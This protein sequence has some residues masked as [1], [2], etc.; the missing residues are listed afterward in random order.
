MARR[1]AAEYNGI[2]GHSL[3]FS[4]SYEE[5]NKFTY[6]ETE[7]TFGEDYSNSIGDDKGVRNPWSDEDH[8]YSLPTDSQHCLEDFDHVLYCFFVLG[9]FSSQNFSFSGE[10]F[11]PVDIL[12]EIIFSIG[13]VRSSIYLLIIS[14]IFIF[15]FNLYC[16]MMIWKFILMIGRT[17]YS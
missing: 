17:M 16:S 3:S 6:G 14:G 5:G 11:V 7:F 8:S 13:V 1:L 9:E 10:G 4:N 12:R 15:S 2:T